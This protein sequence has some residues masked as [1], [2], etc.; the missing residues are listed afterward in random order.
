MQ[1]DT[2]A[3]NTADP[4][5]SSS[6][7]VLPGLSG[8]NGQLQGTTANS[9]N[10][11]GY[12]LS[13]QGQREFESVRQ[14]STTRV[15]YGIDGRSVSLN[16]NKVNVG[17]TGGASTDSNASG[18]AFV[19]PQDWLKQNAG[20][21]VGYRILPEY[22][23]RLTVGYRLDDVDRSNAQVGHSWTNTGS[24]AVTSDLG[25][26]VN[27]KLSFDYIRP[28][29][30]PQL[31]HGRGRISLVPLAARPTPAPTTRLP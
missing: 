20:A 5:P 6:A 9:L 22:D 29:R 13:G 7:G 23:T 8:L 28:Q 25:P 2:F 10:V 17:G 1:D 15:Y 26:Q 16:Q 18:V 24:V 11:I 12:G 27:G 19:V 4:N 14:C 21:E 3:P 30:H 31:S